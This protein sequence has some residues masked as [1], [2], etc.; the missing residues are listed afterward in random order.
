MKFPDV[1]IAMLSFLFI[2]LGVAAEDTEWIEAIRKSQVHLAQAEPEK[3]EAVLIEL[4]TNYPEIRKKPLFCYQ[5]FYVALE[6]LGDRATARDML[7]CLDALVE[8]EELQA[9]SSIYRSVTQSWHR[10]LLSTDSDL[11]RLANRKMTDRLAKSS[12][13]TP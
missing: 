13:T 4:E 8:A 10:A 5:R 3:A 6:G 9:H 1:I 12:T 11:I 7:R 2:P